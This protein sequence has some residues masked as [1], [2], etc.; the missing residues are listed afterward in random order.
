MQGLLGV[1][2]VVALFHLDLYS[3]GT[4]SVLAL[5]DL[6]VF[7]AKKHVDRTCMVLTANRS[8]QTDHLGAEACSFVQMKA[9]RARQD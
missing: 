9:A 4:L 2:T 6:G 7:A 3:I 1:P 5:R 8:A